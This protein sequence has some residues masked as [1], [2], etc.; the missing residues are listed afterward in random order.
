MIT[1]KIFHILTCKEINKKKI[2]S[3]ESLLF[4]KFNFNEKL[5]SIYNCGENEN[6]NCLEETKEEIQ[7]D[8]KF[9]LSL[10]LKD[11]DMKYI[12]FS[13][14]DYKDQILLNVC[15]YGED[16]S[17]S[18]LN[19]VGDPIDPYFEYFIIKKVGVIKKRRGILFDGEKYYS[20]NQINSLAHRNYSSSYVEYLLDYN[21]DEFLNKLNRL[22]KIFRQRKEFHSILDTKFNK[23]ANFSQ[24]KLRNQY[25]DQLKW[26]V[27]SFFKVKSNSVI[28]NIRIE[29]IN[30]GKVFSGALKDKDGKIDLKNCHCET[31]TMTVGSSKN[32]V[33]ELS[34]FFDAINIMTPT[35][36]LSLI[37]EAIEEMNKDID[38]IN[39][40][41]IYKNINI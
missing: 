13:E 39:E 12:L 38:N 17:N 41:F 18:Q 5:T 19:I 22:D 8:L 15:F 6:R 4:D 34:S 11:I 32:M 10:K 21:E 33:L 25:T 30:C 29:D 23:I 2:V 3:F 20:A 7:N 37:E 14:S 16:D 27:Q 24:S 28:Y 9:D 40:P 36:D 31:I 35:L 1:K 26:F